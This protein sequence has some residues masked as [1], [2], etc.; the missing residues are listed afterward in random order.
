MAN[1]AEDTSAGLSDLDILEQA[2]PDDDSKDTPDESDSDSES[3]D[4]EESGEDEPEDDA[5]SEDEDK[6]KSEDDEEES[7]EEQTDAEGSLS[8]KD[9]TSK[10]PKVFKDFPEL[11]K[12]F[13]LARQYE[14]IIPTVEDAKAAVEQ[15][16][17]YQYFQAKVL[18]GDAKEVLDSISNSGEKQA[19]K[20][21]TDN[22]LPS[23]KDVDE[24]SFY[25]VT[26]PVIQQVLY[27]AVQQGS[28]GGDKNLAEAA[29]WIHNFVF[30]NPNVAKP[31]WNRDDR[32]DEKIDPERQQFLRDK[33][34]FERTRMEESMNE[35]SGSIV[36]E[37]RKVILKD[38]D[39]RNEMQPYMRKKLLEDIIQ[40]T[41]RILQKDQHHLRKMDSLWENLRQTGMRTGGK[42][43]IKDTYLARAIQVLPSVR[44]R[45]KAEALGHKVKNNGRTVHRPAGK[46]EREVKSERPAQFRTGKTPDAK[47]VDFNK[48]SDMDLIMG[49]ATLKK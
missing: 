34:N 13:F 22:F 47:K 21:F 1:D 6:E 38:L 20:K 48:T 17:Y 12:N 16:N 2:H 27:A 33:M 9:I 26:A 45:L 49:K 37:M 35:V 43:R 41:G 19:L 5:D 24:P 44:A 11:K 28:S 42:T 39:P 18:Q 4:D 10:Y 15:A 23:L 3:T 25:R 30:G 8:V 46:Q 14:Q 40:E 31:N 29:K 36:S 7:E 32:S